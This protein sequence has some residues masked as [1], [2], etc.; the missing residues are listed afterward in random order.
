M[1]TSKISLSKLENI[2]KRALGFVLDGYQSG[3]TELL[4]NANVPGIK[5][6]SYDIWP[7]K[8]LTVLREL[9]LFTAMQCLRAKNVLMH[10]ETA[11]TDETES[12]TDPIRS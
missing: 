11:E 4:Q 12:E 1:F 8:R 10:W 9:T 2:Q 6:W 3:Y 5:S 7:L